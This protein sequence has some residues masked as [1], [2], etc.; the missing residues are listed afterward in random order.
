MWLR[1]LK[2]IEIKYL[3]Q[4][5]EYT[6]P[7]PPCDNTLFNFAFA[8]PDVHISVWAVIIV[9]VIIVVIIIEKLQVPY[10]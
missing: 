2:H 10:K 3:A 6:A 7:A 5:G 4:G 1:K 8:W 9:I